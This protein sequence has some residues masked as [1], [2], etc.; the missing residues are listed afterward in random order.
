MTSDPAPTAPGAGVGV[1]TGRWRLDPARSTVEFHVRNF[2]GLMTVK[3]RFDRYEGAL[4]LSASPAIELTIEADSLD[5]KQKKRDEHL[6]SADFFDAA[7][8]P[9]VHFI[10]HAVTVEGDTVKVSGR[11]DAAGEHIPLQLDAHLRDVGVDGE[12]EIEATALA[13]HRELGMVWSPLGILRTPSKLVVQ[14]RLVRAEDP[15]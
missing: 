10:A 1:A 4:D 15:R 6:R 8:H 11:L 9:Q 13:D 3:G 7:N 14:G 2:Y 5:T 12:L